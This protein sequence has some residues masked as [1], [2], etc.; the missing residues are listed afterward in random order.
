MGFLIKVG[1][2]S[3]P[4]ETHE[5]VN[6]SLPVSDYSLI[7]CVVRSITFKKNANLWI[8]NGLFQPLDDWT[9]IL[10]QLGTRDFP[11]LPLIVSHPPPHGTQD[12]HTINGFSRQASFSSTSRVQTSIVLRDLL[13]QLVADQL[14]RL[15]QTETVTISLS[16]GLFLSLSHSH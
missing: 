8:N 3:K 16:V 12:S 2:G 1:F 10:K 5:I 11:L 15:S 9:K 4:T 13:L 6:R 14:S 7:G